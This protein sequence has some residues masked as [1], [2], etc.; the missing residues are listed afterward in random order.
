MP[1]IDTTRT[2][3]SGARSRRKA[4]TMP[5]GTP[6]AV[7]SSTA[8]TASSTVAGSRSISAWITGCAAVRE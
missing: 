2:A 5:A 7:L 6:I 8:D 4:A 1:V 3:M